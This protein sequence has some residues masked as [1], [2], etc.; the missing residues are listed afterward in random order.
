MLSSSSRN[1]NRPASGA[2]TRAARSTA[3]SWTQR[4][5]ATPVLLPDTVRIPRRRTFRSG[6]ATVILC[7]RGH[8]NDDG[9]VFCS[10]C[11]DYLGQAD[12]EQRQLEEARR[13]PA[14]RQQGLPFNPVVSATV[15]PSQLS[16]EPGGQGLVRID[17]RNRTSRADEFRLSVRGPA[18][19][20]S[21]V[22][23]EV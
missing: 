6:G 8:E 9:A 17:L 21:M 5:P 3:A 13:E 1:P 7:R 10:V 18:A 11:H 4:L 2:G 22:E 16:V 20:W 14:D 19:E 15:D 23:P 12:L